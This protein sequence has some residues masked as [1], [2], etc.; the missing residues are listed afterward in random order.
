[1]SMIALAAM[2]LVGCQR[3]PASESPS[4]T[5]PPSAPP[6]TNANTSTNL[7]RANAPVVPGS[8]SANIPA[9]TNQ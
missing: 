5:N 8:S 6:N 2:A 3:E 9:A 7:S 1:L 4:T